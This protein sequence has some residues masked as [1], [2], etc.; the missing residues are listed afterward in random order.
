MAGVI[1]APLSS[2]LLRLA[3]GEMVEL[4]EHHQV[5]LTCQNLINR[6]VLA[7]KPDICANVV[8]LRADIEP[9]DACVTVVE[10]EEGG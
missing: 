6:G 10:F 4:T 2:A 9:S 8:G 3:A 7:D 1:G 5:L